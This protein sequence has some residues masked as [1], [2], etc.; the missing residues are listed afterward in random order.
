MQRAA[1]ASIAL[2]PLLSGCHA[3]PLPQYPENYREYAYVA[4]GDS[5]T[6]T[7]IDAVNVRVDRE[8]QVGQN[9]AAVMANPTRDEVYVVNA[10]VAGGSGSLSVID[11]AKNAV[12]ATIALHKKPTAIEVDAD[13]KLAYVANS[14]SNTVS[15]VDLEKRQEVGQIGTGEEPSGLRLSAD[16]KTLVVANRHGNSASIVDVPAR[17]VRSVFSGCDGAADVA[18]L[19]EST[20]AFVACAGGHQVMVISLA[21]AATASTQATP[22]DRLEAMLD[23]GHA[24]VHLALK[25]DGGELFVSNAQSNSISEVDTSKND[26]GGAY[27]IGDEPV[28]GIVT[29]D[30]S[31]LYEAN[32][33]S[34]YVTLYS[35]DEG[36]RLPDAGHGSIH[37]GDG[38]SA[39]AFS[40]SGILLFVVDNRSSDIA[41]LRTDLRSLFTILP[42]GRGP[43]AVAVKVI[44]AK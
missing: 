18:I 3:H 23:V 5:S 34:Q 25:P 16:G 22:S 17:K 13:G 30:N 26:V 12:A 1:I 15:I 10:G 43:N 33:G 24:P 9:P 27:M 41:V 6:V 11:A 31:L 19:P 14:V 40:G 42:T 28:R 29:A 35:I 38:P 32:F 44:K 21:R 20:K 8:L 36:K 2:S 37:V 7:V 4:N 39:M